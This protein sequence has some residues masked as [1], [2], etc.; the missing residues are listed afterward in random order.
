MSAIYNEYGLKAD[1]SGTPQCRE[2]ISKA[3]DDLKGQGAKAFLAGCTEMEM[4]MARD[5][6]DLELLLPMAC[7]CEHLCDLLESAA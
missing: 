2:L 5:C 6:G 4:F 7:L 3:I 1:P